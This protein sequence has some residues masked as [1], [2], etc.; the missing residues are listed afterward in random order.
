MAITNKERIGRA[1]DLLRDGLYPFVEREM[2]SIH[3]KYW[4]KQASSHLCEDRNLKRSIAQRLQEDVAD[5]LNVIYGEWR[6]VFAKTLGNA[7]KNIVGE[8]KVLRNDWAHGRNFSTDDAYRALDSISRLLTAISAPQAD[9]VEKQKQE[10]LRLRFEEQ[11]RHETRKAANTAIESNLQSSLKPWREIVTPHDD[12]ASGRYQEAEFAADLWQVHLD[13]GSDEYRDPTE[14]FRRTYLTEGLKQLLTNALIR[15]SGKGGDPVIELQTNFG[16]GKTHAMLALYHLCFGVSAKDLPGCEPIFADAG[17]DNPPQ[18]VKVA[19]IVGNKISP[20]TTHKKK[21]GT[22]V[23]TLWGEIA[24]QL[25]GKEGY[26]MVREADK[27]STNPGDVL[28]ELFNRYSPCLILIDE[29]VAYARQ[30]HERK[31][32]PAG[33]FDTHFTFAQTIAESAKNAD[34][35]LLVVSIPASDIEIGG[36]RGKEALNRLKNAIGR[37][38]SPWRPANAEE[39]FHIVRRRLFKDITDP[40]LFTARDVAIRAFSQMYRDQVQEFPSECR[41]KDYERRLKDA[42]PIHP[43]LFDRLYSDWSSLDK[44]QRTRGVLRLMAK[45]IRYLWQENDKNLMILPANVPMADGQVQSELTRYL[46]DHWLPIIDKDVDGTNS[47]PV[48]IDGQNQNLGRYSACR[49][50]TRTIYLGS[51]PLQKAA[52][53]GLDIR[54]I[55]LG[56][57]QPGENVAIFGDALRRLTNQATYLYVDN[58][59][60]YWISTQPNVTRTA[61]DRATQIQE[62]RVWEEI[63]KRLKSDKQK[64]EFARIHIAPGSSADVPDDENLG[65]GLVILHPKDSH[66]S[67]SKDSSALERVEDILNSRGASPR[68]CKNLLVFLAV[69]RIK[70]ENLTNWVSQYLAWEWIIEDKEVLNLDASQSKQATSKRKESDETVEMLLR[71]AYQWLLIPTQ[72]DSQGAI[73]WEEYKIQGKDSPILQASRKLIHEE[74]L[75]INYAASTLTLRVLNDYVWKNSNHIDLKTLW[76]YLTNYLYLPR[77]KNEQ[78]LLNAIAE[79]VSNLLWKE[80]FAYATGW[81]EIKQR[82]LDLKVCEHIT[83]TLSSQSLIV[84]P[85]IAQQQIDRELEEKKPQQTTTSTSSKPNIV[86]EES[87]DYQSLPEPNVDRITPQPSVKKRFYGSVELNSLR[88]TKEASQI[89]EEILQHLTSLVGSNVQITLEISAEVSEGIPE[90]V[91]SIV[92]ENCRTLKFKSQ[93]FEK[94]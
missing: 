54:R 33:D 68:Y 69:D 51:A 19:V 85:D 56:C 36:D 24:Y 32:I 28:K 89:A 9:I 64:G 20:G 31:D 63:I 25:G 6:T 75:I 40:S 55:K 49:R 90:R 10:L 12:V 81:D 77:L 65:I 94:D 27:T 52:N 79:G 82:Y 15:L 2:L 38:E 26:E 70:L 53:R 13:E 47:L 18:D 35:A 73:E 62:E 74:H 58:S 46:D 61:I 17:V 80:N 39:S 92:T 42:Y 86:R 72:P 57:T 8:L 43:E 91:I 83:T 11:A 23:K 34:R 84:K 60:R 76:K 67:K 88:L 59:D 30:L 21:D 16:G 37:V 41:E 78:V 4:E 93:E 14:F 45:V 66:S 5:L 1:L 7:E 3:N 29:W 50:V 87:A 44:F 22:V 71:E 48:E